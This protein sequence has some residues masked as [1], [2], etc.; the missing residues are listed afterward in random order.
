MIFA[1]FKGRENSTFAPA[2]L[3]A[4]S[5]FTRE[6]IET[7]KSPW[8]QPGFPRSLWPQSSLFLSLLKKSQGSSW[9]L[10]D[11]TGISTLSNWIFRKSSQLRFFCQLDAEVTGFATWMFRA[12]FARMSTKLLLGPRMDLLPYIPL[13]TQTGPTNNSR[14]LPSKA[15]FKDWSSIRHRL[16]SQLGWLK[17]RDKQS[18]RSIPRDWI[19]SGILLS[20]YLSEIISPRNSALRWS[21]GLI[22]LWALLKSEVQSLPWNFWRIR[23]P[24]CQWR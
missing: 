14:A 7:T 3:L 23:P 12:E 18:L 10:G 16:C 21:I 24:G 19:C 4:R 5:S 8:E 1:G 13:D 11:A 22:Q 20:N 15:S 17:R 6:L 9:L 2:T